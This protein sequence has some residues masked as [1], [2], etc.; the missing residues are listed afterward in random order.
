M[1]MLP[2][3]ADMVRKLGRGARHTAE[4]LSWDA[5][6]R[7]L[8]Q[9]YREVIAGV[10]PS[11]NQQRIVVPSPSSLSAETRPPCASTKCLTMASPSPVPPSSRERDGS[12]R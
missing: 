5:E 11:G 12:A 10:D 7:R 8:D 3:D 9:S 4:A 1:V 2:A 6:V